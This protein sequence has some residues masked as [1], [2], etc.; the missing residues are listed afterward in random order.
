MIDAETID[1]AL[2]PTIDYLRLSGISP[3]EM[4]APAH[5]FD[6]VIPSIL[7]SNT[8]R[9]FTSSSKLAIPLLNAAKV[10]GTEGVS[11][12]TKRADAIDRVVYQRDRDSSTTKQEMPNLS[13]LQPSRQIKKHLFKK[14]VVTQLCSPY[15]PRNFPSSTTELL[16]AQPFLDDLGHKILTPRRHHRHNKDAFNNMRI[17][18]PA[19]NGRGPR[20]S[21]VYTKQDEPT[22]SE[23]CLD[24]NR[25]QGGRNGR[26]E[27]KKWGTDL[28]EEA[29]SS[30][31][32][33]ELEFGRSRP[34][35][36]E[37]CK[38][39][40]NFSPETITWFEEE[41]V[42]ERRGS[43][44]VRGYGDTPTSRVNLGALC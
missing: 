35:G 24:G 38:A 5:S 25:R 16:E 4:A 11:K 9:H 3:S 41:I 33:T 28:A 42:P 13:R 34:I 40:P 26:R 6:T 8:T 36:T 20:K 12:R 44:I 37:H 32:H 17:E 18:R 19:K 30:I 10:P 2:T 7:S 22:N 39:C 21:R 43:V 29:E 1:T 23:N 31:G 27:K 14:P 15:T